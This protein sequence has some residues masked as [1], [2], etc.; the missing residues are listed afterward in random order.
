M[1]D[2]LLFFQFSG[3]KNVHCLFHGKNLKTSQSLGS[4]AFNRGEDNEIICQNRKYLFEK[5]GMPVL[6]VHQIH[7][8]I[9]HFNPHN[10][11]YNE[12]ASLEGDGIATNFA[13]H[14]LMIK[15]ADC[16]PV[17]FA[18]KKGQHIM[19]LHV[20]WRGNRNDF[21][22]QAVAEFCEYYKL[23][24]KDLLAVRGPSLGPRE[25]EFTNFS[26]EWGDTYKTWYTI[27]EQTLDLWALTRHQL[28][29]AGLLPENIYG[30]DFC[31]KTMHT[32]YFS[33]RENNQTGRQASLIWFE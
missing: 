29:Q 24:A 26:A 1:L 33:H 31:T 28:K 20:G 25:A 4:I 5:L 32:Q 19:A 6:E 27:Q 12:I 3:I 7:S 18:H 23:A 21:I 10:T 15:T 14:A 13:K 11:L 9:L 17:L 22:L 30:L 16:Q 8:N 2:N